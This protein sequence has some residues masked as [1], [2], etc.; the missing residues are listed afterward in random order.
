MKK[1]ML[2][3]LKGENEE[4]K[5]HLLG[6]N[7]KQQNELKKVHAHLCTLIIMFFFFLRFVKYYRGFGFIK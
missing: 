3:E 4:K 5:I 2:V 6:E 7:V 1:Y